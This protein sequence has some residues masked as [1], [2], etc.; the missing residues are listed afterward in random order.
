MSLAAP[1]GDRRL[2]AI[3]L[4]VLAVL[5]FTGID[6]CAKWLVLDGIPTSEAVFARYFGHL[7]LVVGL[8]L[9]AGE[10]FVRTSN[11]AAITLRGGFLLSATLLNFT[12]VRFL[13]L[14]VTAAIGFSGPLWIC[15]LSIPMLGEQVGPRRWAAIVVGF[16]GVLVVTRPWSGAM[17]WAVLLS[18]AA[19]LS[20]ALY[21]ILTR[22]L[23]GRDSTATQ[24]F[25]AALLAT[26]GMAPFAFADWTWP[27][28]VASWTALLMI[29]VFGWLSHQLLIIAHRYTAASTLA[30]FIY[31]QILYMTASSWLIFGQPPDVWVLVGAGIVVASGLYIWLRERSLAAAG[32]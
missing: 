1:R 6:T 18:L 9:A 4:M 16:L 8:G 25:H 29:G 10:P 14:T 12:A 22:R 15:L 5:G 7:V 32:T 3:G 11:L 19:A 24:Q 2:Q 28:T 17:H 13:P 21:A 26:I 31:V 23:A 27:A 30:P 20:T